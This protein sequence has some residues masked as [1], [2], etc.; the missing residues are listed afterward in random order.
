[1]TTE[2]AVQLARETLLMA[3]LL[4]TPILAVAT[5]VS[6]LI[7]IAQVMTSIQEHTVATVPRLVVVAIT[8]FVLLPWMLRKLMGF[9]VKI[10]ADFHHCLG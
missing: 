3:L 10:F 4:A 9:T 6:L 5:V 7:N 1:M 8:T 2:V